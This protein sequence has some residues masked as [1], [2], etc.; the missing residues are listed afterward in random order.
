MEAAIIIKEMALSF[1]GKIIL[2][3]HSSEESRRLI[4]AAIIF[5]EGLDPY[6]TWASRLLPHFAV[7]MVISDLARHYLCHIRRCLE[8]RIRLVTQLSEISLTVIG[9]HLRLVGHDFLVAE[10]GISS[11]IM[12]VDCRWLDQ[13][14]LHFLRLHLLPYI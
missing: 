11:Q 14:L 1:L 5:A 6:R 8:S 3:R 4:I 7:M 9:S 12:I 2:V 10:L 13:I